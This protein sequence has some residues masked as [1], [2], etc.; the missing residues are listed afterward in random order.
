ML[1]SLRGFPGGACGKEPTCQCRRQKRHWLDPWVKKIPWRRAWQPTPVILPGE[2]PWTGEPGGLQPIGSQ[3]VGHNW[4]DLAHTHASKASC[5]ESLWVR[6]GRKCLFAD[7]KEKEPG[8]KPQ[9]LWRY[10]PENDSNMLAK[11]DVENCD[12]SQCSWE[13]ILAKENNI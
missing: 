7:L 1:I 2:S 10:F 8:G 5:S 3:R 6:R 9:A 12:I 11:S 4:S 13:P